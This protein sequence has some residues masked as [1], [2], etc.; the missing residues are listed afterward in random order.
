DVVLFAGK[1]ERRKG[2]VEVIETARA[3]PEVRFRMLGWGPEKT[4]LERSAPP[5]VEISGET[6]EEYRASLGRARIFFFP[7]RAETFGIVLIEALASGCAI[8]SSVPL[9]FAGARVQPG[10]SAAMVEAIRRLW[11]QPEA[12]RE[13]GIQNL[14]LAARYSWDAYTSSVLDLYSTVLASRPA[15]IAAQDVR[16]CH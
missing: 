9:D 7:S 2:V 6:G 13:A 5:N 10:D 8:V 12:C 15:A 16:V 4:F 14:K 3:L 1:F 11:E